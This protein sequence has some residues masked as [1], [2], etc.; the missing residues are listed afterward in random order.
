MRTAAG[1]VILFAGLVMLITPGPGWLTIFLGAA[2]LAEE[3]L[4]MARALDRLELWVRAMTRSLRLRWQRARWPLR[5][6]YLALPGAL[7]GASAYLS[8]RWLLA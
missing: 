3:S 8:L 6:A 2:I 4:I 1:A 7:L 5:S